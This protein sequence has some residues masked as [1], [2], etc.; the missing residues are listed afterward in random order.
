VTARTSQWARL[1]APVVQFV[2]W[3]ALMGL[4]VLVVL[5]GFV[6]ISGFRYNGF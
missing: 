3:L 2:G 6:D 4:I 1:V 5:V